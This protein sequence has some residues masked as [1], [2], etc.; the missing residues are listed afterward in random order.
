MGDL[1]FTNYRAGS[2][3]NTIRDQGS[4][5]QAQ[6]HKNFL[7]KLTNSCAKY[8]K[9]ARVGEPIASPTQVVSSF[10]LDLLISVRRKGFEGQGLLVPKL[11]IG[12]KMS[13]LSVSLTPYTYCHL[14]QAHKLFQSEASS[15]ATSA[16]VEKNPRSLAKL[17]HKASIQGVIGK[18][19]HPLSAL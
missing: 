18:K 19:E 17:R 16:A 7:L 15:T 4:V 13:E 9:G 11:R 6:T 5:T 8:Q 10:N 2:T 12:G 3:P 14:S 1:M